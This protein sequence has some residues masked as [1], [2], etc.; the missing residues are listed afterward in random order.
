MLCVHYSNNLI[1]IPG[2]QEL[3]NVPRHKRQQE[4]RSL[5]LRS[6]LSCHLLRKPSLGD[7]SRPSY[8]QSEEMENIGH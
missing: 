8:V 7:P 4:R 5:N 1:V 3:F 2:A 6:L